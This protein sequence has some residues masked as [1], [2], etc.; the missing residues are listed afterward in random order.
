[1]AKYGPPPKPAVE[2][3]LDSIYLEGSCWRSKFR[4]TPA[5][6]ALIRIGNRQVGVHRF[7]YTTFVGPIPGDLELDHVKARGCRFNDCSN[8][9]H[10][11]AVTHRENM[12]R[13]DIVYGIRSAKTYCPKGH[14]Y[15]A[16]NTYIRPQGGRI[17]RTCDR[18]RALRGI[19]R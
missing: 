14:P 19:T 10:L 18:R 13:G 1:M 6:Y 5:G 4:L 8:P 3:W 15:S 16:E 9:D 7:A 2:R 17:C 11:E 12:R